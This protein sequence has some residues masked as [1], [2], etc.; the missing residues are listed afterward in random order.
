MP[1]NYVALFIAK[2]SSHTSQS[3]FHFHLR[4]ESPEH[5]RLQKQLQANLRLQASTYDYTA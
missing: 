3:L 4:K 5:S 1:Y 2:Q